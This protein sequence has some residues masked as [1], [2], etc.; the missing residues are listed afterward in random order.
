VAISE[1][2]SG[3]NLSMMKVSKAVEAVQG[4]RNRYTKVFGAYDIRGVVGKELDSPMV[5]AIAGTYG[6][7]FRPRQPGRFIIGHDGRWSSPAFA[8]AASVGLRESGHKVTRIGLASTPMVYWFGAEGNFDGSIAVSASHLPPQYNGLKLCQQDALPLSSEHGLDKIAALLRRPRQPLQR[9]SDELLQQASPLPLYVARI[10]GF[11]R[12]DKPVKVA[13]DAGNGVGS[14]ATDVLLSSVD[15]IQLWRLGFHLDSY[16]RERSPNPLDEGALDR[17]STMVKQ[18]RLDFGVA[19]DGDADRVVAVDEKGAMVPPDALGGLIGVHLLKQDPGALVLHDLRASRALPEEIRAVGG[20]PVRTRVGH[21]FI[22]RAMREQKAIF[23]MELSGHYYYADL[24]Y[25]DN[26]LR[27]LV[28]LINIASASDRTLSQLIKP[29]LRYPTSGEINIAVK[30][31]EKILMSMEGRYKDGQIDH[32]DGLSVDYED[33][34][35]NV[36]PSHTEPILRLNVGAS[37]KRLL[38]QKRKELLSQLS[39]IYSTKEKKRDQGGSHEQ[40]L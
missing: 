10:R 20:H 7:Y 16:F 31:R 39:D 23:S 30:S 33:W 26:G 18:Q 11:L 38:E 9:P 1:D 32:L 35:F 29:F 34:W 4:V 28:E 40:R 22:K 5:R 17:L 19:F 13:V 3:A 12:P 36:R 2:S 14:I 37:S 24:H 21:A 8:E 25:T 27:T 15:T 6:D